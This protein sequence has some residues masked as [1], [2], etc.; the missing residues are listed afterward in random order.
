MLFLRE[1]CFIDHQPNNNG[2]KVFDR[3][4]E[5]NSGSYSEIEEEC[6]I[7]KSVFLLFLQNKGILSRFH[8]QIQLIL[9]ILGDYFRFCGYLEDQVFLLDVEKQ[10]QR[11]DVNSRMCCYHCPHL[12]RPTARDMLRL[13][14]FQK[15]SRCP[16]VTA[17]ADVLIDVVNTS[18]ATVHSIRPLIFQNECWQAY[19]IRDNCVLFFVYFQTT[20]LWPK[21]PRLGSRR[22][23]GVFI[24]PCFAVSRNLYVLQ[25][26]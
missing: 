8:A 4:Q 22:T 12:T 7:Q 16:A 10:R 20:L 9:E 18:R 13:G 14:C 11:N 19:P 25:L 1:I 17:R 15:L 2:K 24:R 5:S 26:L 6:L 21:Q 23:C 3:N